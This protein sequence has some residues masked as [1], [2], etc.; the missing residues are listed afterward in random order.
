[1][2]L[3]QGEYVALEKIENMYSSSPVVAQIY[4]HGD[5]LQSYLLAVII[6]DPVQLAGVA[7]K[8]FGKKVTAEDLQGL[9]AACKDERVQDEILATLTKEAKRNGLKGFEMIKRVHLS[10]EPFSVENGTMTPTMKIRRKD[11]YIKFKSELD[12]LY[13]LGEPVS[14]L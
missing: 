14:K 7:S 2:K 3:A 4:I 11:A 8:V 6:P 12:Q 9:A 10:L 5:S 1:M 13:A